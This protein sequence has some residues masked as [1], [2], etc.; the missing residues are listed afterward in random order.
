[1]VC[2]PNGGKLLCTMYV[3]IHNRNEFPRNCFGQNK[4]VGINNFIIH[5]FDNIDVIFYETRIKVYNETFLKVWLYCELFILV[6]LEKV[7][8]FSFKFF[9]LVLRIMYSI[10]VYNFKKVLDMNS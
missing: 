10:K 3:P 8:C 6:E 2:Y 7:C 5:Y 4:L 1:M 9:S